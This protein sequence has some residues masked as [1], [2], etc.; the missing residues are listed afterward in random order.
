MTFNFEKATKKQVKARIAIDGPSG[1]GKT[2]TALVCA[3]ALAGDNGKIAVI[4]TERGSAKLYSDKFTFDV[5]ELQTFSPAIYVEAIEAAEKLGY[6]VIVIDSLT[7]AWE[8]EGGVLDMVD[9]AASRSRSGNSFVAWK[10][11][12]PL[13]RKMV[14]TMLQSKCHIVATMRSK[15]DYVQE[16]DERTGKTVIR[17]VG[18]APIQRQGMEYEFTLV[19]DMDTEHRFIVSK[20]RCDIFAEFVKAKPT[21][22]DFKPFVDWLNSGD[23]ET[24]K[25]ENKDS[26]KEIST[27][28]QNRPYSPEALGDRLIVMAGSFAGKTCTEGDRT[29]VRLNLTTMVGGEQQRHD[30]LMYLTGETHMN[31]IPDAMILALKKW[32]HSTKQADDTWIPDDLSIKEAKAAYLEYSEQDAIK[33]CEVN[34]KTALKTVLDKKPF[35]S[36][37]EATEIAFVKKIDVPTITI[38][39]D[40]SEYLE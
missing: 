24:K 37:A 39:S 34:A 35:E 16:K 13:Q 38:A 6:S 40:L 21:I 10:D 9:K 2:Y 25:P 5:L 22:N 20:S 7:H 28:Q 27:K 15:M 36:L 30:L 31:D 12:T 1:A 3:T 32:I 23:V 11:V 4:D 33:W 14:D 17:K 18:M 29:S 19:G 26:E 8:G